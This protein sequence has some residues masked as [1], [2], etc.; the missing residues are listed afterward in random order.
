MPVQGPPARGRL[1]K[2]SMPTRFKSG[3]GTWYYMYGEWTWGRVVYI[4]EQVRPLLLSHSATSL[5]RLLCLEVCDR[6]GGNFKLLLR[7]RF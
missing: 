3:V 5:L 1:N 4:A 6:D 2:F 7:L